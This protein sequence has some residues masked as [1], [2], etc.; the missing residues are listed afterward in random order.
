LRPADL[1]RLVALAAMWGASYLFMRHA[2]PY[3]G[4][5]LMIE[6]RVLVAGVALLAF[7][8]VRGQTVDWKRHW[9]A[10]LFVGVI[11]LDV[12]FLL[13]AQAL[14]TIDA[15]TGAILNALAPLFAALVAAA[16]IRD[17]LTAA[18]L[19]G[20]ALCLVGTAVLVGWRPAPMSAAELV[21]ASFSVAATAIYGYTMVFTKVYLRQATPM[22]ISPCAFPGSRRHGDA[23]QRLARGPRPRIRLDD[24][25]V[26]PLLPSHRR[27][28]AGEGEHRDAARAGIRNA[29]GCRLPRRAPDRR[30]HRGMRDHPRWLRA[31]SRV[32]PLSHR[33]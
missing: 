9:R 29:L 14:R 4:P 28:G 10:Y 25:R 5:V 22:A 24:R 7:A 6:V 27:R 17:R 8:L 26:H 23:D 19:L 16:W 1:A 30:A 3:F 32:G 18:K 33:G 12:P 15:S 31:D 21:A 13:I 2:V 20:I 11:G